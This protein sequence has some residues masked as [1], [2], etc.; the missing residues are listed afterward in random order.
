MPA[1][2]VINTASVVGYNKKL[3]QAVPRMKIWGNKGVNTD[4][5][6]AML[7]LMAEGPS[8]INGQNVSDAYFVEAYS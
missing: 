6:K 5:K 8:K 3:K 7:K 1:S 4:T 2:T